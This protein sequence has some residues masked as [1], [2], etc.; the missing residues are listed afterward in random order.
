MS[1]VD[2]EQYRAK[3]TGTKFE[4]TFISALTHTKE[5]KPMQMSITVLT[6]NP[7]ETV[8]LAKQNGAV[9]AESSNPTTFWMIPY[10]CAIVR[11]RPVG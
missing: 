6:D 9:V 7:S 4:V 5:G 11:I 3:S 1:V 10:P 8:E 2:M